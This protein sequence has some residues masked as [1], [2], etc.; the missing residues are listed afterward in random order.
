MEP[1]ARGI[2]RAGTSFR[3]PRTASKTR[4]MPWPHSLPQR[5]YTRQINAPPA[6]S[7]TIS[8]GQASRRWVT[9]RTPWPKTAVSTP[10]MA[11]A[12][13]A[14]ASRMTPWRSRPRASRFNH[15]FIYFLT[16]LILWARLAAGRTF[17]SV[18][19]SAAGGN[20]LPQKGPAFPSKKGPDRRVWAFSAGKFTRSSL[21]GWAWRG[22]R[23]G[24]WW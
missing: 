23:R 7:S 5:L 11:P 13:A 10:A 16:F 24:G 9:A 21:P 12:A 6:G 22:W 17:S 1:T 8:R 3:R 4:A 20:L 14:R 2:S 15:L 19:Q 18:A